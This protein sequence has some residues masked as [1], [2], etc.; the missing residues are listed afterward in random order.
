MFLYTVDLFGAARGRQLAS[1]EC[2]DLICMIADIVVVGGVRRSALISLSGLDDTHM[3]GA[4]SGEW[5]K[6]TSHRALAN[7]S[8]VYEIRPS[9]L[10]FMAEWMSLARSGSG[11][12]GIFNRHAI[13]RKVASLPSRVLETFVTNPC[14]E[15]ILRASGG[16]CNLTEVVV[17]RDDTLHSLLAKVQTAAIMGTFQST[18]VNFNHVRPIWSENA[19]EERLLGVSLTGIMDHP[20]LSQTTDEARRWLRAMKDQASSAN[21]TWADI[22]G[23]PAS[24]AITTVKPSGTVSQL[25]DSASGQHARY[26]EYYIRSVRA[27]KK[28]PLALFMRAQGFRVEDAFGQEATTDVFFFPVKAPKGSVMRDDRTAIE[29]LEHYRMLVDEWC[30]H[31]A[32]ITV[33]V[34][35]NEWLEVG[36]W[37]HRHFD[38][39]CGVSFLPHSDHT[40][41]Q[42]PYEECSREEYERAVR[43]LPTLDWEMLAQ[44]ETGD[45][46]SSGR[47]YACTANACE[48]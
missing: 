20:V 15:V 40:Y 6:D 22:L 1:V 8:A 35:D 39:L 36:A 37:V 34:R 7:N 10:E 19:Q 26:A 38:T 17:R 46:F 5:W 2:H 4:K 47:E 33:F 31:N 24:V 27:D 18:L 9:A 44:F 3:R 11:E 32:S 45:T 48:I 23:I 42:A 25:V 12:R 14:A 13:N 21:H 41:R 29:Q 28:D 30:E 43:A 16:L